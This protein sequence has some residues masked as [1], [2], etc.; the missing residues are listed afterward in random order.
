[1]HLDV[2]NLHFHQHLTVN[3]KGHSFAKTLIQLL[4]KD[5]VIQLELFSKELVEIKDGNTRYILSN[6][7]VLEQEKNQTRE[8]LKKRFDEDIIEL[9]QKW[10]KRQSKNIDNQKKLKNG[11]KNKKLVTRFSEKNL[12]SF[13]YRATSLLKRFKMTKF[14][15]IKISNAAFE[16]NYSLWRNQLTRGLNDVATICKIC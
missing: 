4:I 6:N 5:N 8:S 7:P 3:Y 12:D 14:Y 10:D 11:H 1:M 2:V 13:K 9:K 15:K 16:I